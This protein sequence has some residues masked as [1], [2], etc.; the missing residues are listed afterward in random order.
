MLTK[1]PHKYQPKVYRNVKVKTSPQ[2]KRTL[3]ATL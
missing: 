2:T 1:L 3:G